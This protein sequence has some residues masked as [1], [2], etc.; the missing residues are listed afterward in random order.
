MVY[1]TLATVHAGPYVMQTL[2]IS[3]AKN[4]KFPR[5]FNESPHYQI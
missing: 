3:M 2:Y 4:C 1:D 5:N